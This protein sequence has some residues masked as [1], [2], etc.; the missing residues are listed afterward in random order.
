M[1]IKWESDDGA[2]AFSP[3]HLQCDFFKGN[4]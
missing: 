1:R 2:S 4:P 3:C